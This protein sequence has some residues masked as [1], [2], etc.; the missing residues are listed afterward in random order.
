MYPESEQQLTYETTAAVYFFTHAFD[1]LSN[2]SAHAVE[3]W[4]QRFQTAEHAFQ[5]RKFNGHEPDIASQ[6]LAAN[7]PW[8]A[9]QINKTAGQGRLPGDWHEARAGIMAE[10]LR[11]KAAHHEDVRECL[12]RTN[13]KTIVENHPVDAFWGCGPAGDGQNMMGVLWM[14]VR[15]ELK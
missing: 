10:I 12:R 3:L 5:W 4:G 9:I 8:A 15:E 2:W 1:A 11:A 13:G 7:S 6:V 14:Q